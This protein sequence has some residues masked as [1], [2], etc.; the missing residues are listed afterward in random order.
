CS[1]GTGVI[2]VSNYG[3]VL[4]WEMVEPIGSS[5][6]VIETYS[7]TTPTFAYNTTYSR[8]YRAKLTGVKYS[9]VI[10]ITVYPPTVGGAI[11]GGG[12]Y[13]N[14]ASGNLTL[15]GHTG[16]VVKW[17]KSNAYG[18]TWTD[19]AFTGTTYAYNVSETTQFRAVLQSGS[20]SQVNSSAATITVRSP[21]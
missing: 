3:S 2:T 13:L 7:V 16:T 17:Q 5:Y 10:L 12:S 21:G 14:S 18:G 8:Y 9:D 1:V 15:S 4:R 19:I 6:A 11:S 20:C